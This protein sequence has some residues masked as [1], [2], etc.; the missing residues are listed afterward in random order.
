MDAITNRWG[1]AF[2]RHK[3]ARYLGQVKLPA[4]ELGAEPPAASQ[5]SGA[6][7]R[8][9]S[10]Q[11]R[12]LTSTDEEAAVA[13]AGGRLTR[14]A[15]QAGS[16]VDLPALAHCDRS[17]AGAEAAQPWSRARNKLFWAVAAALHERH[18][19][20]KAPATLAEAYEMFFALSPAPAEAAEAVAALLQLI[21]TA[22]EPPC[23][24]ALEALGVRASLPQLPGW[25]VLFTERDFRVHCIHS[26][27]PGAHEQHAAHF[28]SLIPAISRPPNL[29]TDP[30]SGRRPL[31]EWLR[32]ETG[33]KH[34]YRVDLVTGNRLWA[35]YCTR[36]LT[37]ARSEAGT[38]LDPYSLQYAVGHALAA[39]DWGA[40][41]PLHSPLLRGQ[42]ARRTRLQRA[43]C[44][45]AV[46]PRTDGNCGVAAQACS[47]L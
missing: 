23:I 10:T 46:F 6:L 21:A 22:R 32:C 43:R 5:R 24:A 9:A 7:N 31:A 14:F 36:L 16:H 1:V 41:K 33:P 35:R 12:F 25:G 45:L 29:A 30:P 17:G 40:D 15:S 39:Q 26:T 34:R 8:A 27:L 13:P 2:V 20:S 18:Q 44:C 37:A 38:E 11:P 28:P 19:P 3:P 47:P 4:E 42:A